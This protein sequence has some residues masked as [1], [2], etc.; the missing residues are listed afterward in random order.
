[1][2]DVEPGCHSDSTDEKPTIWLD[3]SAQPTLNRALGRGCKQR[4]ANPT[5]KLH[6]KRLR[7]RQLPGHASAG[8]G[9]ETSKSFFFNP[10]TLP[11]IG[12]SAQ[13]PANAADF[14]LM[15]ICHCRLVMD[16]GKNFLVHSYRRA[17]SLIFRVHGKFC[18]AATGDWRLE[19]HSICVGCV[20]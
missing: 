18:P 3:P 11:S 5:E 20:A 7:H 17:D 8:N 2:R 14:F 6:L 1:M 16:D 4:E 10:F 12:H 9:T 13:L 19:S 15:C